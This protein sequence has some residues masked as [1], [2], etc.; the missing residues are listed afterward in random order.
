MTHVW[1]L[2]HAARNCPAKWIV[3]IICNKPKIRIAS[4]NIVKC[5]SAP[6]L[7]GTKH[8]RSCRT[9]S[10]INDN[11]NWE[12]QP[13]LVMWHQ[14]LVLVSPPLA[15]A[16]VSTSVMSHSQFIMKSN[17][18]IKFINWPILLINYVVILFL[19]YC[20]LRGSSLKRVYIEKMKVL[21]EN[22]GAVTQHP[23]HNE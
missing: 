8:G 23:R 18:F 1:T 11:K 7:L 20:L 15:V 3:S 9:S 12:E 2:W 5:L 19:F 6:T 17:L 4:A 13:K 10:Q 16:S 21:M 22:Q 14:Y